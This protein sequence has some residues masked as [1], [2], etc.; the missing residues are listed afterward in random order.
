MKNNPIPPDQARWSVYGKLTEEN[1][2]F[3]WGILEELAQPTRG[4]HAGRSRRSA[5]TSPPAWT[6]RAVEKP[7]AT[8]LQ[9]QLDAIAALQ[10]RSGPAGRCSAQLHLDDRRRRPALRLRLDPGLRR[11]DAG[12]RRSPSA[13]G[14]GL[15]DRDYYLKTDAQVEGDP[16]QV[17]GARR[18]HARAARRA[19]RRR[20]RRDAATVMR[21]ETALAKASLTRVEQRDPH[22]LFHKID[23]RKLQALTPA[24]DWNAYLAGS[25]VA[26]ADDRSTSPSRRSS[27]ALDSE[28]H[29]A[30]L[31]ELEDL[32]ALARRRTR[33][34]PLPVARRSSTRTS[35]ST[36]RR[37]A[38]CTRAA[39]AL[40]ALRALRRP[41]PGRG[42]RP[43]VRRAARSRREP[44]AKTLHMT[45]ADRDG[46]GRATSSASPG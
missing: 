37:C 18:A 35:T 14:L 23:A 30:P 11:L 38:A 20:R 8:P 41:R 15:P 28:L 29:D 4:P 43:G 19:R 24:F 1:Q 45:A 25:G 27:Q 12:D 33:R 40:E 13:G 39:A 46:D 31:A 10:A 22:K 36:A 9:P 17:R 34:A 16:R 32:P 42:A 7:G 26:G 21:I 2:R 5:T 3:L 44:K 6:K